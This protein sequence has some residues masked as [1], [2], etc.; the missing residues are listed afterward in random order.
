MMFPI[1]CYSCGKPI[2]HLWRIYQEETAKGR[3]PKNV[4]DELG[5]DR[6]C[7]RKIFLTHVDLIDIINKYRRF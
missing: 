4:L 5:I 1:R 2:N 7:C 6:Y 3:S